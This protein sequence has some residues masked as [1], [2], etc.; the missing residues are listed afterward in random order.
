MFAGLRPRSL[1]LG[2]VAALLWSAVADAEPGTGS[3]LAVQ[4][5]GTILPEGGFNASGACAFGCPAADAEAVANSGDLVLGLDYRLRSSRWVAERID[6][7]SV[8]RAQGVHRPESFVVADSAP[9]NLRARLDHYKGSGFTRG[10]LAPAMNHRG[11]QAAM[12]A[13]FSLGNVSPQ[14]ERFNSGRW[15]QLEL[16]VKSLLH[17]YEE[18]IV[19]TGP[20]FLPLPVGAADGL[21][22]T[23]EDGAG[24]GAGDELPRAAASLGDGPLGGLME[25]RYPVLGTPPDSVPVPTHFFKVVVARRPRAGAVSDVPGPHTPHDT[26][27]AA[28]V[29]PHATSW[30]HG[31]EL[32]QYVTS[33]P[34]LE[35][36]L[37]GR[38]LARALTSKQKG[39][40]DAQAE[41]RGLGRGHRMVRWLAARQ[42][43]RESG[44]DPKQPP[45]AGKG[46]QSQ[47]TPQTRFRGGIVNPLPVDFLSLRSS[48]K[49]ASPAPD[50]PDPTSPSPLVDEK[51]TAVEPADRPAGRNPGRW[52]RRR[53]RA[54]DGPVQSDPNLAGAVMH[55][56]SVVECDTP[57]PIYRKK[58]DR[59]EWR[60]R[61]RQE[62]EDNYDRRWH[63]A[64]L[65]RE[66]A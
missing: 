35:Q 61:W 3:A 51:A 34:A 9:D 26:A 50:L 23:P 53:S 55:L 31:S 8:H 63:D 43:V 32:S 7:Q 2:P 41:A 22:W 62:D 13:T 64:A 19:L 6:A 38:V 56:C 36:V 16:F 39:E 29:L 5:D 28:F 30:P 33:V 48:S 52:R 45:K 54:T 46:R 20:L 25:V 14:L 44:K 57:P 65:D 24:A 17:L 4:P 11:T 37:G 59:P 10:H 12:E 15:L 66:R 47:P 40:V 49:V 60:V 1:A 42:V 21:V 27:V 58:K 18:V